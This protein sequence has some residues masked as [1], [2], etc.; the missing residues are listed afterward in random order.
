MA[1]SLRAKSFVA[2]AGEQQVE[3]LVSGNEPTQAERAAAAELFE[4][5]RLRALLD[6]HQPLVPLKGQ[7]RVGDGVSGPEER[8]DPSRRVR[9]GVQDARNQAEVVAN[10]AIA[11]VV[12]CVGGQLAEEARRDGELQVVQRRLKC[13]QV[14]VAAGHVAHLVDVR[15]RTVKGADEELGQGR[16]EFLSQHFRQCGLSGP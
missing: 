13:I 6:H 16:I 11:C 8:V 5:Q 2:A 3:V 4:T 7:R 1:E 9:L 15:L 10:D 12:A 14:G